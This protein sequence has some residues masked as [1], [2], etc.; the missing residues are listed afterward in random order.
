MIQE[1]EQINILTYEYTYNGGGVAAADF[2]NDGLCDLYF[3]G[4]AVDNKLYLNKGGLR[5]RDATDSSKSAGRKLW[6]TGVAVVDINNDGWLDL[7]LSYSGPVADSLRANQLLINLGCKDGGI[8]AFEDQAKKYGI[9]APGTFTTQVAFFDYDKDGDLDVFMINHGDHFYSPF[10]NTKKLRYT[11]HAQFGNRLYRN[12][13]VS[14]S[15]EIVPFSDVSEQSGIHGGGL[16]FSLGVSISDVNNDGWPDIYVSND[17][18]E[19]DFLYL[20]QKDGTFKDITKQSLLHLSRNGMGTDIADYN[21]DGKQDIVTLDMWPE[22]NFRQKLLRGPDDYARYKLMVDS[23]YHFQQMRNTLQLNTGKTVDGRPL[24]SEI[25]QLAGISST[26]WSWAPLFV[27]LDNDGWKDLFITNGYLRDFTSMDFLKYTVEE[28]KRKAQSNGIELNLYELVSKMSSTKV[29][30]YVYRNK[31]DL[32]FANATQEWGIDQPNLSFGLTYADLDKD[33]DLEVITNNTNEEATIWVNQSRD[34]QK[35]NFVRLA[36]KGDA[37]NT[38]A[39]G[40]QVAVFAGKSRQMQEFNLSR[41]YQ[42]SVEPVL[43]FGLGKASKID[44]IVVT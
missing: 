17:Y 38:V 41:G 36:L 33:V 9:D 22:D 12:N 35:N 11:R 34:Q 2:N 28:E 21:N 13:S 37:S 24:F 20:N 39:I 16:N 14:N 4:N 27:D 31:G 42:S 10:Y 5:F 43:H 19:Q 32:T 44:S 40:A 7:Y 23:G 3:V 26:D 30:D 8:P 6:K 18:E 25:G 15:T 29:H 1:D